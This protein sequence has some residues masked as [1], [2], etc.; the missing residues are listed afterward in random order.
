MKSSPADV[1]AKEDNPLSSAKPGKLRQKTQPRRN[2][3]L[4]EQMT[5]AWN[6]THHQ[7]SQAD[8]SLGMK[9]IRLE[10]HAALAKSIA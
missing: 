2:P 5:Y 4:G 1:V 7:P 3:V 8:R 6:S 10:G 9:P